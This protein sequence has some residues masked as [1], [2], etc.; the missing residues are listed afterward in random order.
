VDGTQSEE[1]ILEQIQ[2]FL[3]KEVGQQAIKSGMIPAVGAERPLGE[4]PAEDVLALVKEI[5]DAR[6]T[7]RLLAMAAQDTRAADSLKVEFRVR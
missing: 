2:S 5:K 1:A 4:A 3:L 6:R 7:I